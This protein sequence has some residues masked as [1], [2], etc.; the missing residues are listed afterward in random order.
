MPQNSTSQSK[1]LRLKCRK[2]RKRLGRSKEVFMAERSNPQKAISAEEALKTEL[3]VNQ[4][5]ID[6]LIQ[7]KIISEKELVAAIRKIKGDQNNK[8]NDS[9]NV[10]RLKN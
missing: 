4:A 1:R 2:K 5:L 7:K 6:I 3:I 8:I 9:K 10:V